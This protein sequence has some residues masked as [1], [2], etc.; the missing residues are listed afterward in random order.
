MGRDQGD[1]FA[2]GT[3][4]FHSTAGLAGTRDSGF[5]P[6][7]DSPVFGFGEESGI[8]LASASS[9][10]QPVLLNGFGEPARLGIRD[11]VLE[12]P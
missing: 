3:P 5:P 7:P 2:D 4:V 12:T 9:P 1:D 8:F 6:S 10:G 11:R